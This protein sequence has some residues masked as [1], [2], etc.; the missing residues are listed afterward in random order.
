MDN[1]QGTGSWSL[2]L[3]KSIK[4]HSCLSEQNDVEL[5][6]KTCEYIFEGKHCSLS[7]SYV[8]LIQH[9]QTFFCKHSLHC[10]QNIS[11]QVACAP[12][13]YHECSYYRLGGQYHLLD[14]PKKAPLERPPVVGYISHILDIWPR[15]LWDQYTH[16]ESS[17]FVELKHLLPDVTCRVSL[18]CASSL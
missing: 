11:F 7:V 14:V 1:Y 8:M 16:G 6:K 4:S 17:Y 3:A 15:C 9:F 2:L 18:K 13:C 5:G 10:L 12:R